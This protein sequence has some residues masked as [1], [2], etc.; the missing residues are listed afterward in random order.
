MCLLAWLLY[1]FTINKYLEANN[2]FPLIY[3]STKFHDL[4]AHHVLETAFKVPISSYPKSLRTELKWA[5]QTAGISMR[6]LCTWSDSLTGA[7]CILGLGTPGIYTDLSPGFQVGGRKCLGSTKHE[8]F[9]FLL[10]KLYLS[11]SSQTQNKIS[12][13]PCVLWFAW[14]IHAYVPYHFHTHG[15]KLD[16]PF[17]ILLW[18]WI[19]ARWPI[20]K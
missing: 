2:L 12:L 13:S 15:R 17:L 1:S 7:V 4:S 10:M 20:F 5:E 6:H 18:L 11:I 9:E 19:S 16:H 8:L 14:K 3:S